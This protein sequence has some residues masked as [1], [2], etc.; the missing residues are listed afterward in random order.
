M[1]PPGK[2]TLSR[3][4]LAALNEQERIEI[5]Q[6]WRVREGLLKVPMPAQVSLRDDYAG[7]GRLIDLILADA[8]VDGVKGLPVSI[9][10]WDQQARQAMLLASYTLRLSS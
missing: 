4:Q 3:M 9:R 6:D 2:T 5:S 10:P 8:G 1:K 7:I